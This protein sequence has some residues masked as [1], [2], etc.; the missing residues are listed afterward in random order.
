M[1]TEGEK[2]AFRDGLTKRHA[3]MKA[4]TAEGAYDKRGH[5]DWVDKEGCALRLMP[6]TTPGTIVT[7]KNVHSEGVGDDDMTGFAIGDA[8]ATYPN[9]PTSHRCCPLQRYLDRVTH[10]RYSRVRRRH[11]QGQAV[12]IWLYYRHSCS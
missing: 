10:T 1:F 3:M 8:V 9:C 6:S 12:E 11:D 5:D 2:K 4:L 7:E